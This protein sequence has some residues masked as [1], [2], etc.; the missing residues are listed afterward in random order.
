[1]VHVHVFTQR[2]QQTTP[3][4]GV[5]TVAEIAPHVNPP[6]ETSDT[7][8]GCPFIPPDAL[9]IDIIPLQ[10]CSEERQQRCSSG[11]TIRH[12]MHRTALAAAL[13]AAGWLISLPVTTAVSTKAAIAPKSEDNSSQASVASCERSLSCVVALW[14]AR[15]WRGLITAHNRATPRKGH[16]C[17][18]E[19]RYTLNALSS[20]YRFARRQPDTSSLRVCCCNPCTHHFPGATPTCPRCLALAM[21]LAVYSTYIAH[22]PSLHRGL[23]HGNCYDLPGAVEARRRGNR[24]MKPWLLHICTVV[25]E[26]Q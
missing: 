22:M 1:M 4:C 24:R 11:C 3:S 13:G 26:Q 16:G 14:S 18:H 2:K 20:K 9:E 19:M 5:T 21:W 10:R 25:P 17:K 7:P 6:H 23:T 8:F 12:A 15:R